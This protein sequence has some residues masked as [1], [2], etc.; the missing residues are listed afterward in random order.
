MRIVINT[1]GC[2]TTVNGYGHMF[3]G[4]TLR[5]ARPPVAGRAQWTVTELL[6]T[7]DLPSPRGARGGKTAQKV[8]PAY[9][10][11]C[12]LQ[13]APAGSDPAAI[14]TVL[15]ARPGSISV[16]NAGTPHLCCGSA[17]TY[18]LMQP[19]WISGQLRVRANVGDARGDPRG[20]PGPDRR[21]ANIGFVMMQIGGGTD[22]PV[23]VRSRS[24]CWTVCPRRAG[25][26][27]AGPRRRSLGRQ[28][29][30]GCG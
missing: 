2:A 4:T 12:S 28:P 21:R 23:G 30:G 24:S 29:V 11:A 1:S 9:R 13:T 7:L 15:A 3:R 6:T 14:R 5:Q 19:R 25:A 26:A 22:L 8:Y 27:G 16:S 17:G 18:N 10:P 20:R